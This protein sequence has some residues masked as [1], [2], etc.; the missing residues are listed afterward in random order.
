MEQHPVPQNITSFQFRLIGDMTIKQFGYLA[1][2]VLLAFIAYKLPLPFFFTWPMAAIFAFAGFGFAFVPIEERPMDIWVFSF[3][4]NVY[5]PTIFHWEHTEP[6]PEPSKSLVPPQVKAPSFSVPTFSIPSLMQKPNTGGVVAL[7]AA[8]KPGEPAKQ[9]TPTTP[10]PSHTQIKHQSSLD[11]FFSFIDNLFTAKPKA[12]PA[13]I[14]RPQPRPTPV[15]QHPVQPQQIQPMPVMPSITG[16]KIEM[17]A[18]VKPPPTQQSNPPAA[19][20]VQKT[21][22][23]LGELKTK[24]ESVQKQLS[25]KTTEEDRYLQLQQQ[26]MSFMKERELMEKELIALRSKTQTQP[27]PQ[28]QQFRKAGVVSSQ[29]EPTIKTMNTD[30]ATRMGLPRLTTFPNVVTGI[31]K[32]YDNN[33]L[34][35]VLVTV[36]DKDGIP[37]RALKTNKLGQFAA[38][39]QLP[40]GVYV[41]EVEDP[42]GRFLF[43]RVQI[44]LNGAVMPALQIIAKS[45]KMMDRENLEKQIFG[46]P[47]A[48]T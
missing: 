45:K 39:T 32:D 16:K 6:T 48:S 17:P 19:S 18:V 41:V 2:G 26:L 42:R 10:P 43:D 30:V 36:Q 38:S 27:A 13:Y 22:E 3:L 28:P 7:P 20:T 33:L 8:P 21:E 15:I 5:N 44:T 1:G 35:G 37:L 29:Q 12:V 24:L 40:N 46:T 31:I 4:K 11:A 9:S 14:V 47:N 34:P 23:N 25:E